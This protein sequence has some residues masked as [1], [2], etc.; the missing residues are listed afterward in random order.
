MYLGDTNMVEVPSFH[1]V[2]DCPVPPYPLA[3][4]NGAVSGI[5]TGKIIICGGKVVIIIITITI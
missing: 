2:Y 4:V 3:G 1:P 5:V